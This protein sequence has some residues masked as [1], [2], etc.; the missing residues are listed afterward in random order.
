MEGDSYR[1]IAAK[2][3]L[4]SHTSLEPHLKDVPKGVKKTPTVVEVPVSVKQEHEAE[5][6]KPAGVMKAGPSDRAV[7]AVAE[8]TLELASSLRAF[9]D[10]LAERS[11]LEQTLTAPERV[12]YRGGRMTARMMEDEIDKLKANA[13]AESETLLE[14]VKRLVKRVETLETEV[15]FL[16]MKL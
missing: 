16:I 2:L 10:E 13:K 9:K 14:V 8:A 7:S 11:E 15:A 1:E 4:K 6:E 3:H 5:T 12:A